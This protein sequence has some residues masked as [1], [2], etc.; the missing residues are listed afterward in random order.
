MGAMANHHLKAGRRALEGAATAKSITLQQEAR[1]MSDEGIR[2]TEE[3][4]AIFV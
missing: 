2:L 1:K 4:R 3:A